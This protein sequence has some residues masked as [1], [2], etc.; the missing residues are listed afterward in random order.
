MKT[1]MT[2]VTRMDPLMRSRIVMRP[3]QTRLIGEVSDLPL[4]VGS[5]PSRLGAGNIPK[6]AG[7]RIT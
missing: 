2:H 1:K 4:Y 7:N 3:R 5:H 6:A